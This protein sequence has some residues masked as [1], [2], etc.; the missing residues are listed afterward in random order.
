MMLGLPMEFAFDE[1]EN[2]G[3]FVCRNVLDRGSPILFVSHDA[4]SVSPLTFPRPWGE[5]ATHAG[6]Y[7]VVEPMHEEERVDR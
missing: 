6:R 7:H 5:R 4:D 1:P 3:V 2:L